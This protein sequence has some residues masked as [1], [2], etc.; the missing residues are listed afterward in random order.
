MSF[1]NRLTLFFVAIVIVP[2]LSVA[3]VLFSLIQDNESGKADARLAARQELAVNLYRAS[4][5]RAGA[6]A[7]RVG[8]DRR[9]ATALR[10]GDDAAARARAT[11]L[12][13]ELDAV[14]IRIEDRQGERLDVGRQDA[15]APA[16]R[17]LVDRGGSQFGRLEVAERTGPSYATEVKRLAEVDVVVRQGARTL[18]ETVAGAPPPRLPQ[19]GDTDVGGED[20]RVASFPAPG[21]GGRDVRV[22][23][24]S[25]QA[26]VQ[27][28]IARSRL[29]AAGVLAGFFVLA[30]WCAVLVSRS[31]Q[32]QI[33]SFLEAARRLGR[34]DFSAQVPTQGRD[35]FAALGEEFNRMA[36]Q[37]EGRLEDLRTE[38]LRLENAMRRLG[39]AFAS[40]LDRGALIEIAMRTAIDGVDADGGRAVLAPDGAEA[41]RSGEP[42]DLSDAVV[43][44]EHEAA[45]AI[46]PRQVAT[47]QGGVLVAPLWAPRSNELH[48]VVSVWRRG[49][50][51]TGAD[52]QL[53]DEL[54]A[55]AAL[56]L[57][58]VALHETVQR[59]AVTDELTGLFNHRRFQDGLN[60]E[61]ERARR[62]DHGMG[63]VM[64]DIDNFKQVNDTYGHQVGDR[65]LREVSN[66]L[67]SQSREI[68]LPARYGGE[69]LAL[70][71]P[72]AD[73]EGAYQL[74]ERVR[75][76]IES[77]HISLDG[78]G[79]MRVTASFGAA[80]IPE[81]A[82]DPSSLIAAA[83]TALYAAKRAGKNRTAR[84][85][86]ER[87]RPSQ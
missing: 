71:L 9:L 55:Q 44:A 76:G 59:Q 50:P 79:V 57:D 73:L 25:P 35:E 65:V 78:Q 47:E 38:R 26:R 87:A 77:L 19:V 86:P 33:G 23:L 63:L 10:G 70:L 60:T 16:R 61:V 68:D 22:S 1:R 15:V 36:S 84:A 6:L 67:R 42:A 5:D 17:E 41:C 37:L 62:L 53:F 69:E 51:F 20:F 82:H 83:D 32:A 2:M 72:G 12:L 74:A 14:R 45:T 11:V 21:F 30:M 24:L 4:V 8:G 52:R 18:G 46:Q 48:G 7:A 85:E 40:N 75:Q 58:N 49:R 27:D 81:S 80:A 64:L 31:L 43:E 13:E 66:V 56:S 29:L 28:D 54:V 39:E 34:G 3:F